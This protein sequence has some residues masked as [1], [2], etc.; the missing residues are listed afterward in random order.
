MQQSI[1]ARAIPYILLAMGI[2]KFA[3]WLYTG[4]TSNIYLADS[5]GMLLIAVASLIQNTLSARSG[6]PKTR[7]PL[8]AVSIV[9]LCLVAWAIAQKW[10]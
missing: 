7:L 8:L 6:N 2:L 3:D 4:R 10:L 1:L 9:G 5:I